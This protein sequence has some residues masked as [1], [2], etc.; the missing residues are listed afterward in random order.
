MTSKYGFKHYSTGD[1]LRE[2]IKTDC[3]EARKIK[4][5]LAEGK[6]A[7]SEMVVDIVKR[8]IFKDGENNN[9][10]LIDGFPRSAEN[11]EAWKRVMGDDVVVKTLVYLGCSFETLEAR[12]LERAKTSGRADD[13]IETIRKRFNTYSEQ[14]KPFLEYYKENVGDAN[15]L[16]GEKPIE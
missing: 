9:T 8:E 3:N 13:N 7:P 4:E 12:L 15:I 10:Y 1:L 2:F 11:Y 5:L 6:L 16:S 14:T